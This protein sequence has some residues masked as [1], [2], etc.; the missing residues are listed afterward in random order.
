M[1]LNDLAKNPEQIQALISL[2]SSLLPKKNEELDS[3]VEV[4]NTHNI[5]TKKVKNSKKNFVNKFLSMP[6]SKMH[7]EDTAIDKLLQVY[8]PTE[9]QRKTP[10]IKV[11][12]RVCGKKETVATTLATESR[13]RYKCNVCSTTPG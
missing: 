9:R 4:E 8:P 3:E 2:L 12:C 1:D 13:G 6:E 10:L 7:K 11:Q 5:K